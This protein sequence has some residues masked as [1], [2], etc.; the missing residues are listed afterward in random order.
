MEKIDRALEDHNEFAQRAAPLHKRIA[1]LEAVVRDFL[2]LERISAPRMDGRRREFAYIR[3]GPALAAVLDAARALVEPE[4]AF[5]EP[6][7]E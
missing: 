4:P 2:A 6:H 3:P 7:S 5:P 1:D